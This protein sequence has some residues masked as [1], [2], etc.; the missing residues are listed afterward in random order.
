VPEEGGWESPFHL[1]C[2]N[3]DCG[4]FVRGWEWMEQQYGV[5]SSYR[6]RLDPATGQASPLAVWSRQALKDR[7]LDAEVSAE[8]PADTPD[9]GRRS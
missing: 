3:D 4:Y 6:Y 9:S 8:S 5:K 7:I 2:F 1:A